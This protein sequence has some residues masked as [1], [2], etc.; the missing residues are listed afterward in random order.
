MEQA[1]APELIR[2]SMFLFIYYGLVFIFCGNGK[3]E[4]DLYRKTILGKDFAFLTKQA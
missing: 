4:S 2:I 1:N 3:L